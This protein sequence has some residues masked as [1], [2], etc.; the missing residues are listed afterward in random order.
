MR[1]FKVFMATAF[2]VVALLG[3]SNT[4]HAERW[5]HVRDMFYIDMDSIEKDYDYFDP[6][7]GGQWY[8]AAHAQVHNSASGVTN[9]WYAQ[10][11]NGDGVR[12]GLYLRMGYGNI[13]RKVRLQDG[14]EYFV[15]NR[16]LSW[17]SPI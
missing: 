9:T 4:T 10:N 15:A 8:I 11:Y 3:M 5:E 6:S 13:M 16:I 7:N 1:I 17:F 12:D 2:V 14:P